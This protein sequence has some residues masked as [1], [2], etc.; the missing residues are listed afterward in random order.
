M[1][2]N[3]TIAAISTAHGVGAIAVIRLSG[4]NA[5]KISDTVF[6]SASGKKL[7]Q[8]APNTLHLGFI[9]DGDVPVDEVIVSLFKS[10]NSYTGEDLV[11]ISCH[12]SLYIQQ[13]ILE[14]LVAKGA[15]IAGPGEF[16]LRAFLN[17][18]MDLS[19]AE[20]V[21]DLI[22]ST[23]QSFHK[24][25]MNQMRGGFSD[26]LKKLRERLLKFVSLIEL[27]LD[28]GEED[29]EF[30]DRNQLKQLVEEIEALLGTLKNSF[31][32]GNA[33]KNGI[34][35]AIAGKTNSGKSTLLNLLLK[36]DRAI[37][38]EIEGTTRDFIEDT[39]SI[40]G[41]HFRFIDTAGLRHTTDQVEKL[42]IERTY[43]KISQA[44]II[45]LMIDPASKTEEIMQ[46]VKDIQK[47][48]KGKDKKLIIIIN[49]IDLL[50]KPDLESLKKNILKIMD[51]EDRL[52]P[53][54]AKKGDNLPM[55][56]TTLKEIIHAE[57]IEQNDVIVTNARHYEALKHSHEAI[58]RVR[59]GL[60]SQISGDL[61]AQDIRETMHY[62]G[63]ITGEITTG[64]ILGN[65]F[66]NFC[67]G[68]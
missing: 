67:I 18:K 35:V 42:G 43:K 9:Y 2:D 60:E 25:A 6:I 63:E 52:I 64:E 5:I 31:A 11:E 14:L 1:I 29:V 47:Q 66:K 24:V 32:L 54:S 28:F 27:E 10:P 3:S 38:S 53:V 20:A 55:L 37:V 17:R 26:E 13:R 46:S 49:K 23:S 56:E 16:T 19:Q 44:D 48:K 22:A 33:I 68:K 30:A 51:K 8:Q 4:E 40:D 61:L 57:T 58:L 36:E 62:L 45:L 15:R 12:G 59:D 65:I 50:K 41:I 34:P 7:S 21:A 39:I